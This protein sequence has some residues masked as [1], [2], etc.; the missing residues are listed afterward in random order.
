[1]ER[2]RASGS[3]YLLYDVA[4]GVERGA[5]VGAVGVQAGGEWVGPSCT[6]DRRDGDAGPTSASS[7]Q[8]HPEMLLCRWRGLA[9]LT[10]PTC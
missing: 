8:R 4:P 9:L 6:R 7:P 5:D 2:N 3:A 10:M 1:M